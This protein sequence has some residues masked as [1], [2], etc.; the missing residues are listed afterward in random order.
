M[1][2]GNM[3]RL[4]LPKDPYW[5]DLPHGVRLLVRP[6]STAVYEAAR[7]RGVRTAR[8]LLDE[9]AELAAVG[10]SIEGLPDLG[11]EDAAAGLSQLIFAQALARSAIIRWEG[12]LERDGSPA[13]VNDRT[14]NDLMLI[15]RM[16]EAFVIDYTRTHERLISE[17]NASGPS[18]N[19][20]SAAGPAIATGAGGT[21]APAPRAGGASAES[22]APM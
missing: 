17:G 4:D 9:H 2:Q 12:V 1:V 8:E 7:A 6:L 20:T 21:A 22:A 5:M 19:G 11:S 10:G 16:A 14:V 15:H 3:I 13:E 18:P